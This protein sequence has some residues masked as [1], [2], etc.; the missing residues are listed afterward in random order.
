MDRLGSR[1]NLK[2]YTLTKFVW[3]AF[4]LDVYKIMWEF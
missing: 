3:L 4:F 1:Q 2:V